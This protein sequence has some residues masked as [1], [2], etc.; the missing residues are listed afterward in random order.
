MGPQ[1]RES[2]RGPARAVQLAGASRRARGGASVTIRIASGSVGKSRRSSAASDAAD[3]GIAR[4][5]HAQVVPEQG[6]A[7]GQDASRSPRRPRRRTAPSRIELNTVEATTSRKNA[8]GRTAAASRRPP[9][10]PR[11]AGSP[12]LRARALAS[13]SMPVEVLLAQAPREELAPASRASR[14]PISRH[15]VS[16][17]T[18]TTPAFFSMP[19]AET[20][21]A[22]PEERRS[23]ASRGRSGRR[24]P[25]LAPAVLGQDRVRSAT[26]RPASVSAGVTTSGPPR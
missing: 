26:T 10:G 6:A 11:R 25:P 2:L 24:R 14:K 23:R 15:G 22:A 1:E 8:V 13:S 21:P 17:P 3:V 18:E 12:A 9:A 5:V 20:D 7:R 16:A 19:A 4:V